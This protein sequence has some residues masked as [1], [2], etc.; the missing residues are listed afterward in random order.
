MNAIEKVF[1]ILL[2][3][4]LLFLFPLSHTYEQE[5]EISYLVAFQAVT[6]FV[7]S[8]RDKGYITPRM[9]NE[10]E[11]RLSATGNSYDI[12]MQHARKRYTPVYQDP[13]NPSTFQNRIEVHDE[14]WYQSQIMQIIFPDNSLA[15]DQLERR[16]ELHTGDLFKVTIENQNATQAGV[17]RS[18]LTQQEDSSSRI[19]IPYGGMVRN[20]DYV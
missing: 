2:A 3:V 11:D 4:C 1:A 9:Y 12:Q 14:V 13:A 17:F 7:D 16:Y 18:F 5:D 10:F 6:E 15:M 8:V 20:E 19:L